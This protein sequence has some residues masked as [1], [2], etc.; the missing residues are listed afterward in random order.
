MDTPTRIG[1]GGSALFTLAGLGAPIFTWWVSGPIMALCAAVAAWGFW[2]V[3]FETAGR[4]VGRTGKKTGPTTTEKSKEITLEPNIDARSAFFKILESSRWRTEQERTTT[5]TRHLVYDW[6]EVRLRGEIHKALRNSKLDSWGEECLQGT[7]TT[8]E[9]LIPPE[10]WDK[11]EIVFDRGSAPRT[12]AHFKGYT[13]RETGRMAWVAVKFSREQ[14][15]QLFPLEPS[16]VDDWRPVF[17]AV[18]HIRERMGDS[19]AGKC[20]PATRLAL[21]QEAYDKR[22]KMRG[23]K[24]LPENDPHNGSEYSAIFTDVDSEYWTTSEINALATSPDCQ[25]NYHTDSQ[26]AFAWG[27]L[28]M[29]E[30]NRYAELRVN[31][32]DILREWP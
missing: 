20:W 25:T 17:M 21:R 18:Q 6:L 31:W 13:S 30:R 19:N 28:G 16:N 7:A 26:T 1:L 9:K 10:A 32:A 11:V 14:I 15:F 23:R 5:D 22:V 24:H 4:I 12:A 29:Y 8:P 2:P 27:K 3:A